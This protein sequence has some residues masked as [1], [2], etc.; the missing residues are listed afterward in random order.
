LGHDGAVVIG[1]VILA[2]IIVI[3]MPVAFMLSGAAVAAL[4]GWSLK[5]EAEETH[6]GSEL[7]ETNY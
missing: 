1:A 2:V 7:L 6:P 3:A 5:T 4:L